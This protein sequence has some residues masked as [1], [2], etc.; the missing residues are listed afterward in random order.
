[1]LAWLLVAAS[2]LSL[3]KIQPFMTPTAPAMTPDPAG[4]AADPSIGNYRT[5]N[6]LAVVGLV[7]GCL[8]AVALLGPA[9]WMLPLAGVLLN[10]RALHGRSDADKASS[11]LGLAGIGLFL[12]V[13]FGVAGPVD[14]WNGRRQVEESSV[15][16]AD[17]WFSALREN[18]PEQA[19]E[20]TMTAMLRRQPTEDLPHY[21]QTHKSAHDQL[22]RYVE[23]PVVKTLLLLGDRAQPRL[24]AVKQ[25]AADELQ[26]NLTRT[27]A[28]T[29]DDDGKKT[30]F[31][32]DMQLDRRLDKTLQ[33]IWRVSGITGGVH[34]ATSW[35]D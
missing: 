14:L 33:P 30:T 20:L 28:V 15:P 1:M 9:F 32:L 18:R 2:F 8:S 5:I 27:Y 13:L 25:P 31:F 26:N 19:L 12:S 11:G 17:A 29:F 4:Q 34:P 24:Y 3:S 16:V 23:E 6:P 21:Y 22:V 10:W 7:L 35:L